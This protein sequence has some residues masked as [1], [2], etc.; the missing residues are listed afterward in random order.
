VFKFLKALFGK[1]DPEVKAADLKAEV[2]DY[3]ANAK[4]VIQEVEE[5]AIEVAKQTEVEIE[6]LTKAIT[7]SNERSKSVQNTASELTALK[8]K[9]TVE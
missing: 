9:I 6:A 3:L 1:V 4:T 8:T 2:L 7:R 5:H